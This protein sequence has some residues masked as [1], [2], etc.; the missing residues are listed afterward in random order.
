M[1]FHLPFGIRPSDKYFSCISKEEY[2]E[3]MRYATEMSIR[4]E[5]FKRFS[6][7]ISPATA[8]AAPPARRTTISILPFALGRSPSPDIAFLA[9]TS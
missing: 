9:I 1:K 4:L 8:T 3:L 5:G 7:D 2:Q 6:G